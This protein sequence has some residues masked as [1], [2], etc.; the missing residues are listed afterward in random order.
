MVEMDCKNAQILLLFFRP[1]HTQDL[2]DEDTRALHDH[3]ST[4]STCAA[5]HA[6]QLAEDRAIGKAVQAVAVPVGLSTKLKDRATTELNAAWRRTLTK[7][8]VAAT[9][10]LLL[11]GGYIALT[12]PTFNLE[13]I[14]DHDD[15]LWQAPH[16][17]ATDWLTDNGL[18]S[19]MPQEY[20]LQLATFVGR[21]NVQ[22][23]PTLALRLDSTNRARAWVY[24]VRSR[25]F[26]L[27]KLENGQLTSYVAVRVHTEPGSK[28]TAVVVYTG[29]NLNAF[30]RP[31]AT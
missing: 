31:G 29:N 26:N 1:D 7:Y 17:T 10:L 2:G 19:A 22:G 27:S 13:R 3:L 23:I 14:S 8:A 16:Q 12:R 11:Y 24:F 9:V 25:D 4:C 15:S 18:G 28:W 20:D 5:R 6:R 30:L 21:R